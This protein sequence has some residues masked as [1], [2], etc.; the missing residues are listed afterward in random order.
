MFKNIT[1]MGQK[2]IAELIQCEIVQKIKYWG[3]EL[4]LK[5]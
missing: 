2:E 4:S 3:V 1:M 5:I